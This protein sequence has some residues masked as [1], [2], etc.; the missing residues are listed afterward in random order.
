M[1]VSQIPLN[2][3]GERVRAAHHAPRDAFRVLER[4]HA[5]AEIVERGAKILPF[6][7]TL[8]RGRTSRSYSA[9][10][11]SDDDEHFRDDDGDADDDGSIAELTVRRCVKINFRRPTRDRIH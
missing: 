8:Q 4:L 5:L 1:R 11:G 3:R 9:F 7:I 10:G 2:P 6:A